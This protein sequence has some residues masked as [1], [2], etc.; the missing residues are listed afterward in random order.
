MSLQKRVLL[1][2]HLSTRLCVVFFQL[3]GERTAA[4]VR[5]EMGLAHVTAAMAVN[6]PNKVPYYDPMSR[7]DRHR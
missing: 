2:Y 7:L 5:Q 6:A 3:G 4:T 1:Q